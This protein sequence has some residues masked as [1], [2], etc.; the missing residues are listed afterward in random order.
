MK[1]VLS[2]L[3]EINSPMFEGS[4]GS[5][6]PLNTWIEYVVDAFSGTLLTFSDL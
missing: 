5:K 2:C 6:N 1:N 4:M 3:S